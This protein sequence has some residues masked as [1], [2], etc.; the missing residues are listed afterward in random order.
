M[1]KKHCPHNPAQCSFCARQSSATA[2]L[3]ATGTAFRTS[4]LWPNRR[5]TAVRRTEQE[6]FT[7]GW[8]V[9]ARIRGYRERSI[10]CSG[11]DDTVRSACSVVRSRTNC[12]RLK[13][14][15][16]Y[17]GTASPERSGASRS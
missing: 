9:R 4:Q 6:V 8:P 2:K 5:G 15:S 14:P 12:V 3:F 13:P 11:R 16:R 17:T 10:E 7:R 1:E